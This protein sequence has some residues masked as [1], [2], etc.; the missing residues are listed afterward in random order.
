[1]GLEA[2][3]GGLMYESLGVGLEEVG[4][5]GGS[6]QWL[7][8]VE[9]AFEALFTTKARGVFRRGASSKDIGVLQL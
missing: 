1:M 9:F 5:E 3:E 4:L 8:I 2:A 6:V 7:M